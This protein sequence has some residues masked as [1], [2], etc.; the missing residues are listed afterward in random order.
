MLRAVIYV[1]ADI[2]KACLADRASLETQALVRGGGGGGG[3][4]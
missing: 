3:G 2:A 4:G 1:E